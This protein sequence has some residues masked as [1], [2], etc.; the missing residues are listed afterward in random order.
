M[1]KKKCNTREA[2]QKKRVHLSLHFSF[3]NLAVGKRGLRSHCLEYGPTCKVTL[4][5][6]E[7]GIILSAYVLS[8]DT[9]DGVVG[10]AVSGFLAHKQLAELVRRVR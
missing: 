2:V 6:H 8:M 9:L 7:L 1:L 4:V 10:G 3:P 5:V